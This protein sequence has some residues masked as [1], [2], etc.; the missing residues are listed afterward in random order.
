MDI[1]NSLKCNKLIGIK[2]MINMQKKPIFYSILNKSQKSKNE[3][4]T[5]TFYNKGAVVMKCNIDRNDN[6]KFKGTY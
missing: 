6:V 4:D 3:Y 1:K 2:P 5:V